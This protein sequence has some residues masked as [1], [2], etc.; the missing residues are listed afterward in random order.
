MIVAGTGHRPNKVGGYSDAAFQRLVKVATTYLEALHSKLPD[1]EPITVVSGMA[2]GW[3]QALAQAA[4][5]LGIPFIAA[6][7]CINQPGVGTRFA[8]P[9]SSVAKYHELL[10]KAKEVVLVTNAVYQTWM[11]QR[12]NEWMVDKS[13]RLVALW[14]GDDEG[15]TAN[16]LNYAISKGVPY[17][18][19]W[20]LFSGSV[21]P[22]D[23]KASF[24]LF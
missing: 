20:D 11:M 2:L 19:V 22:E 7:P 6:V 18:N 3:D 14:N 16:C 12:R 10:A 24:S 9:E 8:W 23:F 4:V 17:D 13:D 21:S 5:D 1:K 15:G